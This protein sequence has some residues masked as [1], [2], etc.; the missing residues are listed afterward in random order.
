M[1]E[2]LKITQFKALKG[3]HTIKDGI[4]SRKIKN[5]KKIKYI[6]KKNIYLLIFRVLTYQYRGTP[7]SMNSHRVR[8][9]D[10]L[11]A[12]AHFNNLFLFL[13]NYKLDVKKEY[14][15]Y[16]YVFKNMLHF[17]ITIKYKK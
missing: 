5:V 11:V 10:Y 6:H 15:F 4:L 3:S 14:L 1:E 13:I 17:F 8:L 9:T 12:I 7:K 2:F 16:L